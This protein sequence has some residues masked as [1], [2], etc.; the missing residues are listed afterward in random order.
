MDENFTRDTTIKEIVSALRQAMFFAEG[1]YS[2]FVFASDCKGDIAQ[3]EAEIREAENSIAEG[4]SRT[5][6]G[7]MAPGMSPRIYKDGYLA[8]LREAIQMIREL[9]QGEL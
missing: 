2:A 7:S 3:L 6:Q 4:L 9:S 1:R 8:G 5:P